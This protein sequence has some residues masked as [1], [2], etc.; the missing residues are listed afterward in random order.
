[1][2]G[3]MVAGRGGAEETSESY[4]LIC[5]AGHDMAF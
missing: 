3:N 4:I 2:A 5:K 1:M